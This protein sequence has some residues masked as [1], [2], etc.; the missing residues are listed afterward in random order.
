MKMTMEGLVEMER[1]TLCTYETYV[2]KEGLESSLDIF[3]SLL[4]PL[5]V[6]QCYL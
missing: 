1:P 6:T 3:I 4:K 5:Q 2:D